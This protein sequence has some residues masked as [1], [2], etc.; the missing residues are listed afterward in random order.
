[1][2]ELWALINDTEDLISGQ[3]RRAHAPFPGCAPRFSAEAGGRE[4][5]PASGQARELTREAGPM[6]ALERIADEVRAC[7]R[8][9]LSAGRTHAVPGSGSGS[10]RVLLVGEG[11]GAEED[12]RGEPFVGKAGQYLDKWLAAIGL[13]RM[14]DCFIT[15]IVKCRPPENRD[16]SME[17]SASCLPYL[18]RQVDLLKPELILALGRV[19]AQ[20]LTDSS[21]GIGALRGKGFFYRG[22]PLMATYHPAAVLRSVEQ[23]DNTL[24][25]AVWEDL[26]RLREQLDSRLGQD[27][28]P[29]GRSGSSHAEESRSAAEPDPENGS[30]A[31]DREE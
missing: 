15:N 4:T 28:Q 30:A 5:A 23:G 24:R 19:A 14:S 2:E 20:T 17:E 29:P 27:P 11:P 3:Y 12:R 21:R 22:I 16:P 26:K 18:E 7:S 1:M 10:P 9:S 25:S 8:C 13:D 6:P 31:S